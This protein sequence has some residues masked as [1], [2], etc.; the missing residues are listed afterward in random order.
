MNGKMDLVRAYKEISGVSVDRAREDIDAFIEAFNQCIL[1]GGITIQGCYSIKVTTVHPRAG[2]NPQTGE[3]TMFPET[4][5]L[6]IK[7][8][9][10]FKL[11]LME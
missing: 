7:T 4:K 5:R 2:F 6:S 10:N 3:T 8:S 9:P 11:K 1:N